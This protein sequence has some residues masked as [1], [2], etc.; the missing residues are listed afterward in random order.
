MRHHCESPS[1]PS[2]PEICTSDGS[3]IQVDVVWLLVRFRCE[4]A[5]AAD[6]DDDEADDTTVESSSIDC[7]WCMEMDF[8]LVLI[9][10]VFVVAD[11]VSIEF[12]LSID[13]TE[14]RICWDDDDDDDDDDGDDDVV[15]TSWVI[16]K[17]RIP[18]VQNPAK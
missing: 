1:L 6:D 17:E 13:D 4:D 12:E 7:E 3:A 16:Q 18:R 5:A 15:A 10:S 11:L 2:L 14:E 9:V 8:S